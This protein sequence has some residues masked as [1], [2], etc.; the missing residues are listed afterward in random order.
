[1]SSGKSKNGKGE[2]GGGGRRGEV[3]SHL[4]A[5]ETGMSSSLMGLMIPM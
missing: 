2:G 5:T 1:M 3:D 4:N